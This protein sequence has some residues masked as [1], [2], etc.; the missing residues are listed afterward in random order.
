MKL[1]DYKNHLE[2]FDM[3]KKVLSLLLAG[4]LV[5][6]VGAVSAVSAGAEEGAAELSPGQFNDHGKYKK[7][8]DKIVTQ[9]LMFAMPGAWQ[10]DITKDPK[11]NGVAG[12]YWWTGWD[13][14]EDNL[15]HGWPGYECDKVEEEGVENLYSIDAP[16]FGNGEKG[17]GRMIIWNNNLDGGTETD[18]TKNPYREA[19]QQT[20][21]FPASYYSR[22]DKIEKYEKLF[23]YIYKYNL[24]K[25]GVPG[26]SDLNLD[27]ETFWDDINRV[28]ATY[29]GEDYD[30]M[31]ANDK[32]I[33]VDGLIDDNNDALDF[34]VFGEKYAANFFNDDCAS[35]VYPD[36]EDGEGCISFHF[37]NMVFVVDL[38]H[39][40]KMEPSPISGKIGFDG[41]FYFYYG[42]GDY[43]TWPTKELN[44]EMGGESGNFMSDAYW[45]SSIE[46]I[47]IPTVPT[48]EAPATTKAADTSDASNASSVP[49]AASDAASSTSNSAVGSATNTSNGAVATGQVSV[50]AIVLLALAAGVGVMV[51]TRKKED[52]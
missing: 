34:S 23:R 36:Q 31:D 52:K 46:D 38:I 2:E 9:H 27:S 37:D 51:F 10:N 18:P 17:N 30:S 15:A 43:G 26:A 4:A 45:K 1:T 48:T 41:D 44:E 13:N 35:E 21:D 24:E 39:T 3:K 42:G 33:V 29:L 47:S 20:R 8:Q 22:T 40:D 28:S 32:P 25:L 6:S 11:C 14:P 50:I 49:P 5:A 19:A 12:M 16:N 7:S